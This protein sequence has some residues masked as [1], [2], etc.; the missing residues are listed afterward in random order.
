[1]E[2]HAGRSGLEGDDNSGLKSHALTCLQCFHNSS[3]L[4]QAHVALHEVFFRGHFVSQSDKF[5]V[6][7]DY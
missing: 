1:M 7:F 4:Q 6:S 2:S 3:V 5:Q